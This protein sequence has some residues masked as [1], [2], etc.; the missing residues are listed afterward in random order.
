MP[1]PFRAKKRRV[2]E[3]PVGRFRRLGA[4]DAT[5]ARL[6]EG[7]DRA[8]DLEKR[9]GL[10]LIAGYS[11]DELA[12]V[13]PYLDKQLP[14]SEHEPVT[15]LDALVGTSDP[16]NVIADVEVPDGTIAEVLR[17]VGHDRERAQWALEIEKAKKNRSSLVHELEK[18]LKP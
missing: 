4:S 9:D 3:L 13:L 18:R 16:Q 14:E 11:D 1:D 15:A 2:Y 6:Q 5:I 12:Q 10:T 7:F 8:S 17:W